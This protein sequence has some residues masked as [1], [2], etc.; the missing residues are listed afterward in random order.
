MGKKIIPVGVL[1]PNFGNRV[2][3]YTASSVLVIFKFLEKRVVSNLVWHSKEQLPR[4]LDSVP[5]Y[6]F[7]PTSYHSESHSLTLVVLLVE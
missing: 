2:G 7:Y 3:H 4:R 6:T 5:S 1:I